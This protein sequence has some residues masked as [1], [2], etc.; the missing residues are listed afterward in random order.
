MSV[1]VFQDINAL[2][3]DPLPD[4]TLNCVVTAIELSANSPNTGNL[5]YQ[6][7]DE[8]NNPLTVSPDITLTQPGSYTVSLTNV[9]NNCA[10]SRTITI[11]LD[12]ITPLL[13]IDLP[14]T[15]TCARSV[16][17]LSAASSTANTVPTWSDTN[18][19]LGNSW[20]QDV[21][22]PGS[23]H[24]LVT[25]TDNGCFREATTSV[26]IDTIVP[27]AELLLPDTL[28]CTRTT[29]GIDF[30]FI[31]GNGTYELTWNG[32]GVENLQAA[33][34]LL[35]TEPGLYTVDVMDIANGCTTP[36]SIEVPGNTLAPDIQPLLPVTLNCLQPTTSVTAVSNTVGNLGFTWT[37]VMGTLLSN[38]PTVDIDSEGSYLLTVINLDNGCDSTAALTVSEDEETLAVEAGPDSELT[39]TLNEVTLTGTIGASNWI[40]NWVNA[41]GDTLST[42]SWQLTTSTPGLYTLQVWNPDNGC[43][44]S[45]EALVILSQDL[46]IADAGPNVDFDCFTQ[47]ATIN[48]SNSSS[49][50]NFTYL[51]MNTNGMVLGESSQPIFSVNEAGA[52]TL[53]VLNTDNGCQASD[54]V[55][56]TI[57]LPSID[58]ILTEDISCVATA[59]SIVVE[60]VSAG[61]PPYLYSANGGVDWQASPV[62]SNLA[63]GSYDI[64]VQDVNGCEATAQTFIAEG[65]GID[66]LL[67]DEVRL[68]LGDTF[69]LTPLFN[70]PA[71]DIATM[72][73]GA[74]EQLDCTDC[75]TAVFTAT[76][77]ESL[78]FTITTTDGC[79]A[80]A[81][82]L[83]IVDE[84]VPV[85]IPNAFSPHDNDGNNDRFTVFADTDQVSGVLSL[86]IFNRWG[87]LVYNRENLVA[88]DLSQ[89]WDGTFNG[90]PL[91]SGVFVYWVEV[92]LV[93]GEKI[94]LK[95]DVLLMD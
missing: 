87:T 1:T 73:W 58:N 14:D 40:P 45:D 37:N 11:A 56:V 64:Q 26:L 16:V 84:R 19:P 74:S 72:T 44:G 9:D 89:G 77:T 94:L 41:A 51:L 38:Q 50:I 18:G 67:P 3:I 54:Q 63:V 76:S 23:Y 81:K 8:L 75:L 17:T 29:T 22:Q 91:N 85:Y 5:Q 12:T 71:E 48:A 33:A 47:T 24:L 32:P 2:V 79:T 10:A 53:A 34:P 59:G 43:T 42:G 92:Q 69:T 78:F 35:A 49:G 6:W 61:T 90:Q 65:E 88:N 28:T 7:F 30:A 20:E 82:V 83:M 66:V 57:D 36:L 80:T 46:P 25:N 95:G 60:T 13:T 15:I 31:M 39:C 52:Y 62:F 93:N 4:S 70:R 27:I 68:K 55:M 21:T 86:Q